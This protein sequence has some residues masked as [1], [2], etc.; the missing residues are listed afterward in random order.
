[1][2]LC[3]KVVLVFMWFCIS[4]ALLIFA[5]ETESQRSPELNLE[6]GV[7][8]VGLFDSETGT[9]AFLGVP[10]AAPPVGSLRWAPP[11][12]IQDAGKLKLAKNFKEHISLIGTR[13]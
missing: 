8:F 5:A 7:T 2:W 11:K 1:M 6:S 12:P 13:T 3:R 10:F 9:E 4:F